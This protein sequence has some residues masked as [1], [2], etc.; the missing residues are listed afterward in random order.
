MVMAWSGGPDFW[1]LFIAGLTSTASL[2]RG[3][4]FLVEEDAGAVAIWVFVLSVLIS[5]V[6]L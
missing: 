4:G 6:D 1:R 3:F 2:G 5:V